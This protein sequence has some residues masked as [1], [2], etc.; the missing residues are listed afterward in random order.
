MVEFKQA[1]S[2]GFE[3]LVNGN[4]FGYID[5]NHGYFTDSSVVKEFMNVSSEDLV[6][7]AQKAKEV[8]QPNTKSKCEVHSSIEHMQS[9]DG[10]CPGCG[11]R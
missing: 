7:I 9:A 3:V 2:G 1:A 4:S 10:L 6:S 5:K 11:K 8:S